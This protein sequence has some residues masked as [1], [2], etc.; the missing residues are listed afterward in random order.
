MRAARGGGGV[1]A[2]TTTTTV[3]VVRD[4]AGEPLPGAHEG[5][6]DLHRH[7]HHVSEAILLPLTR[8]ELL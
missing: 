4:L 6:L 5:A 1:H 3:L 7:S 8:T 2:C